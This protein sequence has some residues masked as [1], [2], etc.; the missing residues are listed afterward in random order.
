MKA[1]DVSLARRATG[2]FATSASPRTPHRAAAL[3]CPI[4]TSLT[5]YCVC[6]ELRP[7][8]STGVTRLRQYY[9]RLRHPMTPGLSV[10][11]HQLVVPD[12]TRGVPVLRA[13][14]LCTCCRHYPGAATGG[15]TSLIRPVISAF[16][17]RVVGSACASPFRGLLSLHSRYGPLTRAATISWH[18]YPKASD[19]SSPP[20]LLRCFR[21]ER[22]PG[23]PRTHWKA[24]PFH[25]ARPMRSTDNSDPAARRRRVAEHATH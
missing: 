9:G 7:L 19:I 22:F 11:G 8:P 25:G 5:T 18:A 10:T 2:T 16:P 1:G 6:L 21:L 24:S 15:T 3:G 12:H 4:S 14:S 20:C 17:E 13:H 23:G